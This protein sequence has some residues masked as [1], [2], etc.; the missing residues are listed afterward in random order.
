MPGK[1]LAVL[2][3][4][5][6]AG[7]VRAQQDQARNSAGATL[8]TDALDLERDERY[9]EAAE[10]FR[11]ALRIEPGNVS[12]VLGLERVLRASGQLGTIV[13][14]LQRSLA[15]DP[16][17]ALLRA[18]ELRVWAGLG[19]PDSLSAAAQRWIQ[20][21]PGA[22][23][24]YREWSDVLLRAGKLDEAEAVLTRGAQ[25]VGATALLP[26]RAEIAAA[27]GQW[28]EAARHWHGAVTASELEADAAAENLVMTPRE[29]RPAVLTLLSRT[30]PDP[31][32]RRM[33]AD[34]ELAWGRPAA[35]WTL[36]EGALPTDQPAAARM[37][38]R[39]ADRT[40]LLRTPEAHRV[41]G[42]VLERLA[43]SATGVAQERAR[44]DAARAYAEAGDRAAAERLLVRLAADSV[45]APTGAAGATIALIAMMAETGRVEEAE[46]QLR[47][48]AGRMTGE[49]ASELRQK[50]AWAWILKGD[51]LTART[52]IAD[53]SSIGA[54]AVRGWMALFNGDLTNAT[55]NFR[56]AG[57][58]AGTR[59]QAIQRTQV[60]GLIQRIEP[61]SV[62]DFGRAMYLL[63]QGDTN[64][65]LTQFAQAAESL[66]P[67]GGKADVL[68]FAGQVA[69]GR[70]DHRRAQ[71]FLE[72]VLLADPTGPAAPVA[73]Y[74]LAESLAQTGNTGESVRRLEHLILTYP[75]SAMVPQARRLL[76]QVRNRTPRAGA[77]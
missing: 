62:A 21:A 20:L 30:L 29:S 70:G 59:E 44:V 53:D 76:D 57:P 63:A 28:V 45:R 7:E 42:A 3:A 56:A 36:L 4:L 61:D 9:A 65:A 23:E 64:A 34:L 17:N 2:L 15:R 52:T 12:A 31:V 71:P 6:L 48:W 54:M 35:A 19:P 74:Q 24:P 37:L 47:E 67:R 60:A 50:I 18:V 75:Q 27:R 46:A 72:G 1:H 39:F 8:V 38:D 14:Q 25:A 55:K 26:Q 5:L 51:Y 32:A 16:R 73:E 77:S 13:P 41:R 40:R 43:T 49:E 69:K 68:F 58:A 11:A 22:V 66:P 33:A 10:G